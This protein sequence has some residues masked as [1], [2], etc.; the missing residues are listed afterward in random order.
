MTR[1][2][3]LKIKSINVE[4]LGTTSTVSV[5]VVTI[6]RTCWH[7]KN[8]WDLIFK[9]YVQQQYFDSRSKATTYN[10]I[11][12]KQYSLNFWWCNLL[13]TLRVTKQRYML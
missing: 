5:Q 12:L 6:N 4:P 13:H 8:I 10:A 1:M 3:R 11:L 2:C 9:S 7:T